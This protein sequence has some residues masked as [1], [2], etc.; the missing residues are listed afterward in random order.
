[1]RPRRLM[2]LSVSV[3]LSSVLTTYTIAW[4]G[5]VAYPPSKS[6]FQ[7]S[8]SGTGDDRWRTPFLTSTS[9]LEIEGEQIDPP[10]AALAYYKHRAR[11]QRFE[12]NSNQGQSI[13]VAPSN[14]ASW[15]LFE[16][17]FPFRSS[18]GW[19]RVNL[20]GPPFVLEEGGLITLRGLPRGPDHVLPYLPLWRGLI[21]NT[22]FYAAI[23]W[24]LL[25]VPRLI[26]RTRRARK[27]LC[28][29]CGYDM[30]GLANTPC[31]E[32]GHTSRA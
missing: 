19:K 4:V 25:A 29:S 20:T 23:W 16:S 18:W 26:R 12:G 2:L 15:A 24:A 32:C 14:V 30:R 11:S 17:G 9:M 22:L 21:L 3:I 5:T 8:T 28:R 6:I 1:M 10:S 31:P 7:R 27:G 13:S